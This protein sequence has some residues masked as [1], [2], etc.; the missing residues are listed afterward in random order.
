MANFWELSPNGTTVRPPRVTGG[1]AVGWILR[2]AVVSDPVVDGTRAGTVDV[3]LL[4]DDTWV[5]RGVDTVDT[6]VHTCCVSTHPVL[7]ES[8]LVFWVSPNGNRHDTNVR[9]YWWVRGCADPARSPLRAVDRSAWG[10][11]VNA[12]VGDGCDW[13]QLIPGGTTH[14]MSART[15]RGVWAGVV[16]LGWVAGGGV[17]QDW[18]RD[19]VGS[20]GEF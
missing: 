15:G 20:S 8:R 18:D 14:V 13:I 2:P 10:L 3:D 11:C 7:Q 19:T 9:V 5:V 16:G 1:G 12:R 6:P 4:P 17:P